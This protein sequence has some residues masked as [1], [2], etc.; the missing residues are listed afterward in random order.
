MLIAFRPFAYDAGLIAKE[1]EPVFAPVDLLNL[2]NHHIALKLMIDGMPSKPFSAATL[3]HD[4]V[5]HCQGVEPTR[6][7][8]GVS[9]RDF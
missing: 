6:S 2:T 3:H 5:A 7:P 8:R 4:C 9:P 1:F